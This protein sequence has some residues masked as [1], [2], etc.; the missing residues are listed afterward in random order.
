M[1]VLSMDTKK[2]KKNMFIID[3]DNIHV[4]LECYYLRKL[5]KVIDLIFIMFKT[6]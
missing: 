2:E 3:W 5:S 1:K 4:F 6:P